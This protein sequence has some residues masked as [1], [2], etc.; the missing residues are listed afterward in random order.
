MPERFKHFMVWFFVLLGIWNLGTED[1]GWASIDFGFALM[2]LLLLE[3]KEKPNG[4]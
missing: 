4:T 1:Y 2:Y 3:K